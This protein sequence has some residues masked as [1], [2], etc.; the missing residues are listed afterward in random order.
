PDVET[1]HLRLNYRCGSNIVTASSYALGEERDYEAV[2]GAPEGTV[3]FHP[4]AGQY[5]HHAEHLFSSI[6][7]E[8]MA[9]VPEA[10]LGDVAILYPAA[11]IGNDL[12]E[13][14]QRHGLGTI[15]TDSNSIYPRSSRLMRWLE[16][17]AQWCCGGWQTSMPRFSRLVNEGHR[18]FSEI[19]NSQE[20]HLSFQRQL[21]DILWNNRDC[22]L[23]LNQWLNELKT[24]FV[25]E[26]LSGCQTMQDETETLNGLIERTMPDGN[27][28]ALSLQQFAGQS[29]GLDCINLSTL[30]SSKGREFSIVIMFA[31]DHGKIPWFNVGPK[32]VKESRRLFY[33]GFTRAK[34]ELHILYSNESPSP[35]VLEVQQRLQNN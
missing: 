10:Q 18:L 2:E 6:L 25:G 14:A 24:E 15:R 4:C 19:L 30:H 17:C 3:F 31:M 12:A 8:A 32:Q 35:F 5:A 16:Q 20:Q 13:A 28:E 34:N 9:R 7:P 29:E 26:L 11:W 22:T 21:L 1:V 23:P 33:V 27:L